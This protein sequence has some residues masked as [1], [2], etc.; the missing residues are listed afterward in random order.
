MKI[1]DPSSGIVTGLPPAA[2]AGGSGR[3][4]SADGAG[5]SNDRIQLSE[6]SA[7]LSESG[8]PE[9]AAKLTQLATAVSH[10]QY[11]VDASVVSAALIQH[12]LA[13]SASV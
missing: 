9:H 7:R 5:R 11:H 3:V 13:C 6:L 1:S 2:G 8:S 10:G 12:S 4:K